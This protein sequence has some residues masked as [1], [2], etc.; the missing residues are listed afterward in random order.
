[1]I[2]V[3]KKKQ[4]GLGDTVKYLFDKTGVSYA[5]KK[6]AEAVGIGDCGCAKRQEMLNNIFP[7][8]N[9]KQID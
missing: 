6:A 8:G 5:V 7:Y 4:E 2:Q 3:V 9:T 1:M